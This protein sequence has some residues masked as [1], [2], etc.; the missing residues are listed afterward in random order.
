MGSVLSSPVEPILVV[1]RWEIKEMVLTWEKTEALWNLL[2]QY[3]S[4]F[5]DLTRGDLGNF[6][7]VITQ[8]NTLFFEVWERFLPGGPSSEVNVIAQGDGSLVGLIWLTD[9]ESMVD[10]EVHMA[11]FDRKPREKKSVVLA[12][13]K[14]VF[15]HYPMHR[16]TASVPDIYHAQHRFVKA[17]GL[18]QEGVKRQAIMSAGTWHDVYLFGLLR[19]EAEALQ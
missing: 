12:L 8:N 9:I 14:W 18:V 7:N 19:S 2:S 3:R 13:M 6:I 11:F 10:A 17:L 16:V 15:N 1:D 4:L 5:S